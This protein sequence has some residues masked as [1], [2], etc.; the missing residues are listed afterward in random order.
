M[1]S[2]VIAVAEFEPLEN[3]QSCLAALVRARDFA[4]IPCEFIFVSDGPPTNAFL[5]FQ[6]EN[7]ASGDCKFLSTAV[8]CGPCDCWNYAIAV[9][10]FDWIVRIDCDDEVTDARFSSCLRTIELQKQADVICGGI[11]EVWPNQKK[12]LAPKF[13]G[14]APQDLFKSY[15][16]PIYHVTVA[17]R[18]HSVMEAGWYQRFPNFIDW[19]LWLRM[20][21]MKCSFF[22]INEVFAF[23]GCQNNVAKRRSG[24][25][26]VRNEFKFW[27]SVAR[28]KLLPWQLV[29][30]A[31]AIRLPLR[32][33]PSWF[34]AL[35][36]RKRH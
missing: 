14:D 28:T 11:I 33:S 8:T 12:N 31:L 34:V 1:F 2:V 6:D 9:A 30:K 27:G 13:A 20:N 3:L 26:F 17:M 22:A 7:K 25:L 16:N 24:W 29:L 10:R 5:E 15:R 19:H 35:A 4:A 23:V 32:M 36:M 21:S 18:R